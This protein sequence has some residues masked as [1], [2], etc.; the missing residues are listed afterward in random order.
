[1]SDA[2]KPSEKPMDLLGEID[3]AARRFDNLAVV[4]PDLQADLCRKH[5]AEC[6]AAISKASA[7]PSHD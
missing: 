3:L 1:M 5:A 7:E 6:R 2:R 4:L